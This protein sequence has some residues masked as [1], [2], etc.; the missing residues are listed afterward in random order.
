MRSNE[1]MHTSIT[2]TARAMSESGDIRIMQALECIV[3]DFVSYCAHPQQTC[4]T[5]AHLRTAYVASVAHAL[6]R[7]RHTMT[8]RDLYYMSK[9]L[10]PSQPTAERTIA[11]LART[12][13]AH[14]N[15]LNIVAAPKGIVAGPMSYVG[16]SNAYVNVL[17]FGCE[18]SLIPSRPER[19]GRLSST[20]KIILVYV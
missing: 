15:D 12:V 9:V 16:E 1:H 6:L 8:R 7:D 17:L 20:A 4:S 19:L 14:P 18:G 11:S 13:G 3:L 2:H 5:I 10:F